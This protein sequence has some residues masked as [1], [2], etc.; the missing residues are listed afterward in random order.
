MEIKSNLLSNYRMLFKS[1]LIGALILLLL[2][3]TFFI[4][5]LVTERQ[6]R[7]QEAVAEINS[8]WAAPQTLTGPVIGVPYLD[9]ATDNGNRVAVKRWAYFLPSKLDIRSHLAPEKR[10]RGIYPVIVYTTELDIRGSFDSLHLDALNLA[11]E[12][13]F[14][15]EA[16]VFFDLS[17]PQGLK[18]DMTLHLSATT[19]GATPAATSATNPAPTSAPTP[20]LAHPTSARRAPAAR[21]ESCHRDSSA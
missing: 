10:Y 9:I 16:T 2:I 15:K 1:V 5:N 21:R 17:D 14:W 13:I 20:A 7:Q 19:G 12:N 8:H 4:Q 18:E 11:P 3:P 6:Q